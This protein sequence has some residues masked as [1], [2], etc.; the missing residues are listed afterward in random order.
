MRLKAN[1][2]N[3]EWHCEPRDLKI[4]GCASTHRNER[5]PHRVTMLDPS[6]PV[7]FV[8]LSYPYT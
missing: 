7:A 2:V 3:E 6:Y 4:A 1:T 5:P 8:T